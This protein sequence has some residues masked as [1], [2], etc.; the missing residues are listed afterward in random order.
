MIFRIKDA[1]SVRLS[2]LISA[3]SVGV[4]NEER[5]KMKV[6]KIEYQKNKKLKRKRQK[7]KD[8]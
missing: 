2:S 8:I 6:N 1:Q 4:L 7:E 5:C 3:H